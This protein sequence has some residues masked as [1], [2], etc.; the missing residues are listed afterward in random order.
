MVRWDDLGLPLPPDLGSARFLH[1][2]ITR[3]QIQTA[4]N[5]GIPF[6]IKM[7][8]FLMT[9]KSAKHVGFLAAA[10]ATAALAVAIIL[11]AMWPARQP[12]FAGRPVSYWFG[13]LPVIYGDP[14]AGKRMI[15]PDRGSGQ[16]TITYAYAGYRV[17]PTVPA[18]GVADYP[19]AL[20][21]IRAM[22]TNGLPFLLHKLEGRPP[23]RVTRLIQR[24][25]GSWPVI[26]TLFRPQ[27]R[28]KEQGQAV[29]GLLVLCPLPSDAQLK[30]RSLSV[31]FR[32]SCWYQA[33]YVL[34]ANRDPPMVRDALSAYR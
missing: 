20:A 7:A 34:K 6:D 8:D 9:G 10:W 33:G 13:R 1:E 31:D 5:E 23:S 25:A 28:V 30:L 24:Y 4:I 17:A 22:G 21:A 19:G 27:D 26:R 18:T 12:A 2:L 15:Y 11:A 16:E 32:G 29:A 14:S 3:G